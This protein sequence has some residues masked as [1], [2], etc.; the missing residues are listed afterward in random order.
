MELRY[1]GLV[2]RIVKA[3]AVPFKRI[4]DEGV[5]DLGKAVLEGVSAYCEDGERKSTDGL[6]SLKTQVEARIRL[7]GFCCWEDQQAVSA[8]SKL[9]E[10]AMSDSIGETST[11]L[12]EVTRI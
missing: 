5:A 6:K 2:L 8:M 4:R 3:A 12:R 11:A 7:G 9:I 10:A 1:S